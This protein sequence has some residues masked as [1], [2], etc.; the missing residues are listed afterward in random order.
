MGVVY[1]AYDPDLDRRVALAVLRQDRDAEPLVRLQDRQRS[2]R[3]ARALASISHPNVIKIHDV[4][5]VEDE[6][7]VAMEASDG[8]TLPAWLAARRDARPTS[9]TCSR[10]PVTASPLPMPKAWCI[11]TSSPRR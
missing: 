6:V 4:G 9:S 3:D 7:F 8:R 10:A 2:V 11:A 5:V 1:S